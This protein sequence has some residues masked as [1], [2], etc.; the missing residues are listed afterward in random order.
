MQALVPF[1][2]ERAARGEFTIKNGIGVAHGLISF[3][4]LGD[5]RKMH[6]YASG[7]ATQLAEEQEAESKH[8]K[9]THIL[10]DATVKQTLEDIY[11][12]VP[13]DSKNEELQ[14]IYELVDS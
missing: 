12:F 6:F 5:D 3:G 2:D 9:F 8:G 7:E 1:N 13:H 10:V 14:G 4:V 11:N